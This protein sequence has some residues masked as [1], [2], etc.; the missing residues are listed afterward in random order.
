MDDDLQYLIHFFND[1]AHLFETI[2]MAGPAEV[3]AVCDTISARTGWFWARFSPSERAG[4]FRRRAFVER[5]M[6][7][8]YTRAHG[9]LQERVPVFYF[10]LVPKI[11]EQAAAGLARQ[12]AMHG[13]AEAR[14]LMARLADF[15]DTANLTFTLN[16]SHTAY[17]RRMKE[18]GL[19]FGGARNVRV[20][21][22]DHDRV[23]PLSM[24]EPIHRAYRTHGLQYEVQVW[25][26]R[27]LENLR[28][29]VL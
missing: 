18:A 19:D 21:L 12:R 23:F 3:D 14:V 20:D 6:Y 11:T 16:D 5:A 29:T 10:Y 1:E 17:G 24:I 26:R 8:D 25:D 28:Y 9:P 2:T 15:E 27:L 7:D 22:P 4:Y 13:E